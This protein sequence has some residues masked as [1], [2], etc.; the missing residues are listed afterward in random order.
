MYPC[1]A[2]KQE[3]YSTKNDNNNGDIAITEPYS[4]YLTQYGGMDDLG[5]ALPLH[6]IKTMS[7]DTPITQQPLP[8]K[9]PCPL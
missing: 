4:N 2:A 1:Y 7:P 9:K 3:A 8:L 6:D 5:F